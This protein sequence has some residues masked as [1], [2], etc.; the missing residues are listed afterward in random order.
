MPLRFLCYREIPYGFTI[1]PFAVVYGTSTFQRNS[2]QICLAKMLFNVTT[3]KMHLVFLKIYELLNLCL[4]F[5]NSFYYLNHVYI[6]VNSKSRS[7]RPVG[8]L[9]IALLKKLV[10]FKANC[11][12]VSYVNFF[13]TASYTPANC[14][15]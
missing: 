10:I 7:S 4:V 1:K 15:F 2:Y 6:H 3:I 14:C 9:K 13:G 11:E 12:I 5:R 8:A